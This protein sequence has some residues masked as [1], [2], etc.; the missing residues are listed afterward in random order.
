MRALYDVLESPVLRDEPESVNE[1]IDWLLMCI[2]VRDV[3][4]DNPGMSWDEAKKAAGYE[5]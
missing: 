4:R 2:E 1:T 3:M 5:S